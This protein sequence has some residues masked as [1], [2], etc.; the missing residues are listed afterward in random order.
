[1]LDLKYLREHPEDAKRRLQIRNP[2]IDLPAVL[3]ADEERR[4]LQKQCEDLRALKN[5]ASKK[6]AAA[7]PEERL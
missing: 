1:M 3:K 2:H 7:P 5:E 4:R 6:I